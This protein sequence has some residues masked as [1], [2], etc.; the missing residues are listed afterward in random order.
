MS[1]MTGCLRKSVWQL[2]QLSNS[3]KINLESV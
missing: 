2:M 3:G 1:A